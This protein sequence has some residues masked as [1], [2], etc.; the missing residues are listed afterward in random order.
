MLTSRYR[1]LKR[2]YRIPYT[3]KQR[4]K[5]QTSQRFPLAD[6]SMVRE[7]EKPLQGDANMNRV[8]SIRS[9]LLF[10]VAL[11]LVGAVAY[12]QSDTASITGIVRDP[13]SGSVPNSTVVVRNEA[14]GVERR[15]TTNETGFYIVS[16]LPP[17]FYSI[18]VEAPGFKKFEKTQNKLDA[19][20]T[21]NVD[22]LMTVGA[23]TETVNVVAEA[24]AIQSESA[25]LGRVVTTKEIA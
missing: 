6:T 8:C 14:T 21:A 5:R 10:N 12:A 22:I 11:L 20:I 19:N 25:T 15:A 7:A 9:I 2:V 4:R 17:G 24:T 3:T 1:K 13:S 16:N 23:A 18:T